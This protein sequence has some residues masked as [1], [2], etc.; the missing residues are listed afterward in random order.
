MF[1]AHIKVLTNK[2]ASCFS[3]YPNLFKFMFKNLTQ[4][5]AVSFKY[6]PLTHNPLWRED[7]YIPEYDDDDEEFYEQQMSR[8]IQNLI[9][10]LPERGN[11]I[12]EPQRQQ[13][14]EPRRQRRN[15]S[16]MRPPDIDP[17]PIN[18]DDDSDLSPYPS[19]LEFTPQ[20][21]RENT[22]PLRRSTRT[23]QPI[24]RFAEEFRRYYSHSAV[25]ND[26]LDQTTDIT[27]IL[28]NS[29]SPF[30]QELA[31]QIQNFKEDDAAPV[32]PVTYDQAHSDKTYGSQW[33][34][35]TKDEVDAMLSNEVWEFTER[36]E[37]RKP[38]KCKWVFKYKTGPAGEVQRCKA[39][40]VARGY[41]QV[42]GIDFNETF[43][44]VAKLDSIRLLF[45]YAATLGL[46]IHQMDVVNAF[47]LADID[48]EIYAE[49][50]QGVTAP[51]GIS[52][53]VIK[54]KKSM[55]GLKQAGRNWYFK[56]H[57]TLVKLGFQRLEADHAVYIHPESGLIFAFWVDDI[58]IL[59]SD[60]DTIAS[61]KEVMLQEFAMKDM[62]E[63]TFFLGLKIT[64]SPTFLFI[65]QEHYIEKITTQFRNETG[66]QLWHVDIPMKTG[67][68]LVP[69]KKDPP[70]KLR[71][72]Q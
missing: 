57:E 44:A 17:E 15:P 29:P 19:D 40:L 25:L 56:L 60:P 70:H 63:L 67:I 35:A 34:Q 37:G 7:N 49:I 27:E 54:I 38:I 64:R 5:E 11:P 61:F 4:C 20:P 59:H 58:M 2:K 68:S 22:P 53:P 31:Q 30:M 39:R 33:K 45:S 46:H 52:N 66:V 21:S 16:P 28:A 18:S 32:D 51:D 14:E 62:G 50:P 41:T 71:L 24:V 8:S 6:T 1:F 9:S 36:P 23:R 48:E 10:N 12:P 65:S 69:N 3:T 47:L 43:A 13:P 26:L 42:E 55:Y 72:Y